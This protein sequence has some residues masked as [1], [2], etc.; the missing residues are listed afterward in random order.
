MLKGCPPNPDRVYVG[1]FNVLET[2]VALPLEPVVVK[3]VIL[4]VYAVFQLVAEAILAS[5]KVPAHV[6]VWVVPADTIVTFVSFTNVWIALVNPFR[7]VI[8]A[9]KNDG[10]PVILDQAKDVIHEGLA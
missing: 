7:D 5:A 6:I 1:T 10:A 4:L 8:A 3:L 2:N 9:V